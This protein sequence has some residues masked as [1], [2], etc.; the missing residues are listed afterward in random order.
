M[1]VR[2]EIREANARIKAQIDESA[3][4][5]LIRIGVDPDEVAREEAEARWQEFLESCR[6]WGRAWGEMAKAIGALADA[7]GAGFEEGSR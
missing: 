3:R 1:N 6:V 2:R 5:A 4:A 7:V